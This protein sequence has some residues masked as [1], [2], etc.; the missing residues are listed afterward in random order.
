MF[1]NIRHERL[2]RDEHSSIS[3][4]FASHISNEVLWIYVQENT[5]LMYNNSRP[6]STKQHVKFD[7]I[8]HN[9]AECCSAKWWCTKCPGALWCCFVEKL[10]FK[11]KIETSKFILS[12]LWTQKY[13][14]IEIYWQKYF[15]KLLLRSFK[16]LF[17]NL[18]KERHDNQH[19]DTQN[20]DIQH[21]KCN[22]V[23][24][25]KKCPT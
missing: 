24:K 21:I 16:I 12:L 4:P 17:S 19:N 13:I 3:G 7:S 1:L 10:L 25:E 22:P 2:D 11:K 8:N 14:R 20:N 5:L 6:N 18:L 15:C 23:P 9:S